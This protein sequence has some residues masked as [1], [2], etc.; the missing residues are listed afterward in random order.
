MDVNRFH[1]AQ[2]RIDQTYQSIQEYRAKQGEV[3]CVPIAPGQRLPL[4]EG[5]KHG[6]L[7]L[8]IDERYKEGAD[9]PAVIIHD[10]LDLEGRTDV[11]ND[12]ADRMM[13][14]LWYTDPQAFYNKAARGA[15]SEGMILT[16]IRSVYF[17]EVSKSGKQ[18]VGVL[19][20][21]FK[22]EETSET[23][24]DAEHQNDLVV[25]Y[26]PVRLILPLEVEAPYC[27]PNRYN[28]RHYLRIAA[29]QVLTPAIAKPILAAHSIIV[30]EA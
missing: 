2:Q 14:Q 18:L 11:F 3:Q 26:Q 16:V 28:M 15:G 5:A 1:A 24:T 13:N 9:V 20:S 10:S 12:R 4:L 7:R 6:L 17:A 23:D 29:A 22:P 30:Q 21:S 25:P 27:S 8:V 19:A